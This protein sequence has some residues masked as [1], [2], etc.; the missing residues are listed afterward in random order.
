MAT[1]TTFP[2]YPPYG[3]LGGLADQAGT[4][5]NPGSTPYRYGDILVRRVANG[6]MVI[7]SQ[8]GLEGREHVAKDLDEVADILKSE[9]V[10]DVL[11]KA[12]TNKS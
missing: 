12:T 4:W 10:K 9:L 5:S 8:M 3:Q 1:T 11:K 6:F 2:S 7:F